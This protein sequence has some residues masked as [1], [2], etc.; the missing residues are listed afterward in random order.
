MNLWMMKLLFFGV[1]IIDLTC[2]PNLSQL[3]EKEK[4]LWKWGHTSE[5][6]LWIQTS[7]NFPE[8]GLIQTFAFNNFCKINLIE[9][10][11]SSFAL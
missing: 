9:K 4:F 5:A 8:I 6:N 3:Y 2:S 11:A 10:K 1:K 7:Q